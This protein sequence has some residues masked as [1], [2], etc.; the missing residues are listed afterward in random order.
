MKNSNKCVFFY[1]IHPI[2]YI[3]AL[4]LTLFFDVYYYKSLGINIKLLLFFKKPSLEELYKSG[5]YEFNAMLGNAYDEFKMQLDPSW[6]KY[7]AWY[8]HKNV[9]VNFINQIVSNLIEDY[10]NIYKFSDISKKLS[11]KYNNKIS[12][13]LP[14]LTK[15][16]SEL[17]F[18]VYFEQNILHQSI[19]FDSIYR[20]YTFFK[21]WFLSILKVIYK[22][23]KNITILDY[24]IICQGINKQEIFKRG[25]KSCFY[26]FLDEAI[27]STKNVL[28][29]LPSKP[30]KETALEYKKDNINWMLHSDK[31]MY[32]SIKETLMLL[33]NLLFKAKNIHNVNSTYLEFQIKNCISKSYVSF[34]FFKNNNFDI[35]LT[36]NSE[37]ENAGY[38]TSVARAL[39][40]KTIMWQ[41]SQAG[42]I[43]ADFSKKKQKKN[44]CG[45][46]VQSVLFS[47]HQFVWHK[48][49]INLFKERNLQPKHLK[50][51][52]YV[53]GPL[54]PGNGNWTKY[55]LEDLR[56]KILGDSTSRNVKIWI[57]IFDLPTYN[58]SFKNYRAGLNRFT[59]EM[60]E[61]FFNDLT[62]IITKYKN[63]GLIYKPKRRIDKDRFHMSKSLHNFIDLSNKLEYKNRIVMLPNNIDPYIPFAL[64]DN[65][66]GV[67]FTSAVFAG[68]YYN[69]KAIFYD[70]T[71]FYK[72]C[73]PQ[74]Y[75]SLSLNNF[76]Q[77]SHQV[78]TWIFNK[79]KEKYIIKENPVRIFS[80][81][82]N[83]FLN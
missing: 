24:K 27:I 18:E 64:A 13:V 17:G 15:E 16:L 55:N 51:K 42:V 7:S 9:K 48:D 75:Y 57:S 8:I 1:H 47:E 37:L 76:S 73:Y 31:Y 10:E 58:K 11:K 62:K 26:F 59:D 6:E 21:Y 29:I 65:C 67:P 12:L 53:S 34:D 32:T 38:D 78:E 72:S 5:Q 63:I 33:F 52:F 20:K 30:N 70:P 50:P 40:I 46:L 80:K 83:Q 22:T 79:N 39:N 4:I 3:Y 66:I 2:N 54:M 81:K 56:Y 49:D 28:F 23:K 45:R 68:N 41:Y 77:L 19:T 14:F 60:Q 25:V 69:K 36:N 74:K 43:P 82:L 35:F 71:K 44:F 61:K